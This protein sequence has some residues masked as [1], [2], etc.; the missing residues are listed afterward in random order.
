MNLT[1]EESR[2]LV[3]WATSEPSVIDLRLYGARA[4]DIAKP[5]S[6]VELCVTIRDFDEVS[7]FAI[8]FERQPEWTRVL[9]EL[10]RLPV[11]LVFAFDAAEADRKCKNG[12]Q[13]VFR[14]K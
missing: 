5:H 6:V 12:Y 9:E 7:A 1:Q 3:A 2:A 8:F 10:L 14:R 4:F 13:R 11:T